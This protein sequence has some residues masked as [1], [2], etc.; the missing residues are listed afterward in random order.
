M[1]ALLEALPYAHALVARQDLPIPAWLFAWGAS[2]VLI[3]SFFA[4]SAAW[5]EPRFEEE[6]W[7]PLAAR[8]SWALLG[9]PAQ[10][11]CGAVGVFLLGVAV[12]AGIHGR[13]EERRVG[14]RR[15]C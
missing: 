9:L 13:S 5:R 7:R 11:L 2:M 8:L 4:L 10:A 15:R 1:S 6:R 14:K 3:V 12:Y